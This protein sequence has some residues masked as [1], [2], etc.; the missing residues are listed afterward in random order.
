MK[1]GMALLSVSLQINVLTCTLCC[2][3]CQ[4]SPLTG[5]AATHDNL[6]YLLLL[7]L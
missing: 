5:A 2:S 1:G 6:S 3:G 4:L 7:G